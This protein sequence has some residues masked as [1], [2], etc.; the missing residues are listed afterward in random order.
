[1][2]GVLIS[3]PC[4]VIDTQTEGGHVKMESETGVMQLIAKEHQGLWAIT[5]S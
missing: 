1:M 3:R 2:I 5:R 4:E